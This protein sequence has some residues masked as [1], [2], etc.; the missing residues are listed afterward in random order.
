M[1]IMSVYARKKGGGGG[2]KVENEEATKRGLTGVARSSCGRG[3]KA[4]ID[5]IVTLPQHRRITNADLMQEGKHGEQSS[6]D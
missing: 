3:W 6:V 5:F 2:D 4:G 1:G